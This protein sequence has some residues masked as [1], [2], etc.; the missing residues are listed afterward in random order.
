MK[1]SL[2][3]GETKYFLFHKTSRKDDLPLLLPRLLIK[4]HKVESVK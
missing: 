4:E 2:H 1:L 3:A